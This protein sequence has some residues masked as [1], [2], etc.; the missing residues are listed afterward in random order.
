MQAEERESDNPR[1]D[2]IFLWKRCW[3]SFLASP[4]FIV[5]WYRV[6]DWG[7]LATYATTPPCTNPATPP[8]LLVFLQLNMHLSHHDLLK[9]LPK[10][11]SW[12]AVAPRREPGESTNPS[13]LGKMYSVCQEDCLIPRGSCRAHTN[14]A[15]GISLGRVCHRDR[16]F[17]VPCSRK[18]Y[19]AGRGK[20]GQVVTSLAR[21]GL[22][23]CGEAQAIWTPYYWIVSHNSA[24]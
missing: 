10:H 13:K 17:K 1:E 14:P 21:S 4:F 2:S 7:T 22:I 3:C 18:R 9:I 5:T 11:E 15:I 6:S 23:L 19:Q 16:E 12:S 8:N 20:T 24:G